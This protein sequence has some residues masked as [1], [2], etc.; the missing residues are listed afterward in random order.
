MKVVVDDKGSCR[1]VLTVDVPADAVSSG[2]NDILKVYRKSAKIAGFRKNAVLK[3]AVLHGNFKQGIF[4]GCWFISG[5]Q[6]ENTA[7][8]ESKEKMDVCRE[9]VVLSSLL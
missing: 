9:C 6:C 7:N 1:K 5:T 2:Y 4:V 8:K 3:K